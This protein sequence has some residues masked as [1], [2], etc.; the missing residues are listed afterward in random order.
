MAVLYVLLQGRSWRVVGDSMEPTLVEGDWLILSGR[1]PQLDDLVVFEEPDTGRSAV[2]RVAGLPGNRVRLA[3]NDL[4]LDEEVRHRAV[5]GAEDFVPMV[6]LPRMEEVEGMG[7]PLE[8]VGFRRDA[9]GWLMDGSGIAGLKRTPNDFFLVRGAFR[10]GSQPATDLALE[11]DY[12]LLTSDS[13]LQL[14]LGKNRTRFLLSLEQ[15]GKRLRLRRVDQPKNLP[16]T[17]FEEELDQ[18]HPVGTLFFTLSD[19]SIT[20]ALNGKA[21]VHGVGYAQAQPLNYAELPIDLPPVEHAAVG[22]QG[23]LRI[24]GLRLGRDIS[25]RA[26]GTYGGGEAFRLG[27]DQYFLIGDNSPQSR[28]SRHYGAVPRDRIRGVV[29]FT[30]WP[31]GWTE[32]GWVDD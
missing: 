27:D 8:E 2:K 26:T 20:I 21:R 5:T 23:P 16:L 14:E 11:V 7:F 18:A 24:H 25:Y 28:D 30:F 31:R 1:E 12:G 6:D 13:V 29:A 10:E 32:R 19:R 9:E 4:L 17:L 22:G 15:D 3:G